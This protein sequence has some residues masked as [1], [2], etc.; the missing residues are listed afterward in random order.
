MLKL[1]IITAVVL[2]AVS[3][4]AIYGW[5]PLWFGFFLLCAAGCCAWEWSSLLNIESTD[6]RFVYVAVVVAITGLILWADQPSLLKALVLVAVLCWIAMAIDLVLRPVLVNVSA[7]RWPLLVVATFILI[8]SVTSLFWIRE[9]Q[10]AGAIVFTIALVAAADIGAYFA[11]KRFGK[12]KLAL[13]ISAGKTIEGAIG[14]LVSAAVLALIVLLIFRISDTSMLS[15]L[16]FAL[17]AAVF[18]IAGDLYISRVKRV[19]GVKDSGNLLP[20]HGG[21]LDR[22]DGLLAAIP[23]IAFAML[24]T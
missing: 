23:W 11:G 20:G 3:L 14:G 15:L 2:A 22:F 21:V 10:S 18:S 7:V 4:W 12:R 1:R 24:W 19:R 16:F 13:Q 5:S 6:K 8:V 17:V 9:Y